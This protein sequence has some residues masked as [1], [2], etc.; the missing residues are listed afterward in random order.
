MFFDILGNG[1]TWIITL[2]GPILVLIPD[3]MYKSVQFIYFPNPSQKLQTYFKVA[4]A[5]SSKNKVADLY[6]P[7]NN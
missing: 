1:K 2:I 5:E 4:D 3:F 7:Q 6:L